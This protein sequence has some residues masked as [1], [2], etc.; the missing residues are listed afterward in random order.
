[1]FVLIKPCFHSR[2][3]CI[4]L[5]Y[6]QCIRNDYVGI[7]TMTHPKN[8]EW[9]VVITAYSYFSAIR[10]YKLY[11]HICRQSYIKLLYNMKLLS[12]HSSFL[13]VICF[14]NYRMAKSS[15]R[16]TYINY[17]LWTS[18]WENSQMVQ[19]NF[20]LELFSPVHQHVCFL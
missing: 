17:R 10:I 6:I 11:M 1:M 19:V 3:L 20:Y 14:S 8:N 13:I 16:T 18:Y 2:S 4:L 5:I 7:K 15:W 9:L 12:K